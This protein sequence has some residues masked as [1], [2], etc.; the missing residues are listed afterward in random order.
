MVD[1]RGLACPLPVIQTQ[2]AIEKEHP[3]TLEVL[4][5][6]NTAVQNVKRFAARAG[7]AVTVKEL[8][9]D[10]FSLLLKKQ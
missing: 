5:D 9:D 7:Y 8:E 10:E 3:D 6:N 2:R 1:A 4:V